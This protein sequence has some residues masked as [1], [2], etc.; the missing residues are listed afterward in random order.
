MI[1]DTVTVSEAV[2]EALQAMEFTQGMEPRH[3]VKLAS[4]GA[5]QTFDE[6]DIIFH[7]GDKSDLLYL[8]QQGRVALYIRV[9]DRG[10]VTILTVEPGRLLGWSSLFPPHHKTACARAAIRTRAIALNAPQ[11]LQLCRRDPNL[12]FIVMQR[13]AE[14]ITSRLVA[15]RL[16]LLDMFAPA[17]R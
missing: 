17:G 13:V 15:T 14:A 10:K 4:I 8:V 5:G 11:L 3:I 12:G 2:L 6:G 9:P 16:Q 1:P 7:E